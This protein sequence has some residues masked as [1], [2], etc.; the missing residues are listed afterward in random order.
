VSQLV[1]AHILTESQ[2]EE[3]ANQVSEGDDGFPNDE[4]E[5]SPAFDF[6]APPMIAL[7][8]MLQ[9]DVSTSIPTFEYVHSLRENEIP[10]LLAFHLWDRVQTV[11]RLEDL[12][13]DPGKLGA[14][15]EEFFSET[16]D[17]APAAMLQ[18]CRFVR[19]GV[20]RLDETNCWFLLFI[21]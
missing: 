4:L 7:G 21:S 5:L 16:W 19:A 8:V 17:E 12:A 20:E 15:Y 11:A 6:N 13:A 1:L 18:A 10:V 2:L 3:Y 9:D 14:F